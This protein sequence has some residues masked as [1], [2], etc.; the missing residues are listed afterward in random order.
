MAISAGDA[1][2]ELGLDTKKLDSGLKGVAGKLDQ[3]SAKWGR[4]MKI[5]GGVMIGAVAAV[6]GASLKMAADFDSAM[7]EVNTMMLLSDEAFA[8][9]SKEVRVLAKDM[10]V[11]AVASANALYQAISAGIPKENV[12]DFLKIATEAAIGGVTETEIAVDGL[13]TVINAFKMPVSDAQ[14]VADLMFTTVK[15]GKT[16]FE[17]LSASM[18]LAAPIAASIGV[19]FEDVMAT[20]ATLT[21]QGTPTAMAFTQ[22]KSAMVALM[23]PT[24]E[25]NELIALTGFETGES[26]FKTLGFAGTMSALRKAAN[27]NNEVLAKAF[28]RVEALNA[29]LG[30]T[31][32]NAEMAAADIDSM[33]NSAGA[34]T[35]AFD[36]MEKTAKR[37]FEKLQAQLK[38]TAMTLGNAL[39]PAL[40]RLLE[41]VTPIIE[42]VATWIEKNP[43]LAVG[44]LAAIGA[45]GGLLLIGGFLLPM[46][47][48]L[49]TILPM[50]GAAFTVALGPIGLIALAI[51]AVI[52]IGV[53]VYK[54]WDKIK[55][56]AI[57]IWGYLGG[58][59]SKLGDSIKNKFKSDWETTRTFAN[60]IWGDIQ[61][62]GEKYGGGLQ[63]TI[64]G[65]YESLLVGTRDVL[66]AMGVDT[67][68]WGKKIRS[69]WEALVDFF[70][71]IPET[72]RRVFSTLK[73][74]MLAPF[75][76]AISAIET[77]IGWLIK[78]VNKIRISV[79]SWVPGIGGKGFGFDIPEIR[80]PT[81]DR[82]GLITEPTLLYGLRSMRPY[83]T[84]KQGEVVSPAGQIGITNNFNIAE[85]VVREEADVPR[86]ARELE[87][88]R[89]SKV[90]LVGA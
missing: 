69:V 84:A 65:A 90:R 43:K 52:A 44:I 50:L 18:S 76:L 1:V 72:I 64:L 78:Q 10:G 47:S 21:K 13:T 24:N 40:I 62:R 74:I 2:I 6:G 29:V 3:A 58:F 46:L 35:D 80:L 33:A 88:L 45:V 56:K 57:E 75:R 59:F 8:E 67:E 20:I 30:V 61:Q 82:G 15:G 81:F 73:D 25:M 86:I 42:K 89:Q 60:K 26:M 27:D 28:G 19:S 48:S 22:V 5:A 17:E 49:I 34:A 63:G 54:N 4:K 41:I 36:Q 7:R 14:K 32:K 71:S 66:E 83:A 38:D 51:A 23:K 87:R 68:E 9:F 79:P 37:K 55:A 53:L 77:A 31:G 16:T 85:L 12:L 70:R 11:D 39:M